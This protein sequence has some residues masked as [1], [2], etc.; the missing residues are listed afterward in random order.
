M[1][2]IDAAIV[3]VVVFFFAWGIWVGFV[4]QLAL[5]VALLAAFVAA[6]HLAGDLLGLLQP[7][8]APS[9]LTFILSYLLLAGFTYLAV[10]LL[11]LGLRRVVTFA[12]TPWFDR[13]SGGI[14]GLLKAYLLLALLYFVFAGVAGPVK[15][16]L[17]E[18]YFK[19]HLQAGALLVQQ[20]VRDQD[21][22]ELFIPREPAIS[23]AT[24]VPGEPPRR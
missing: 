5:V 14:F 13:A 8:V 22:R 4:R 23:A 20:L 3:A 12:L 6:G 19:P 15:P 11:I 18:S 2:V 16:L 21:I 9:R 17:A 10:R 7:Y 24:P 1:T